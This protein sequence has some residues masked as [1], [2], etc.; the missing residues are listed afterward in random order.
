M[1]LLL[2]D[3]RTLD[4][5]VLLRCLES[6][7]TPVIFDFEKD[8]LRKNYPSQQT[9]MSR[10]H[11]LYFKGEMKAAYHFVGKKVF[12]PFLMKNRFCIMF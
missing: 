11:K 5:P 8:S 12:L 4:I 3:N 1:A 9:V 7:V 2:I 6:N 10:L